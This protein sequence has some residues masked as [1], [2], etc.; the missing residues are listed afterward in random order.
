MGP[1]LWSW[2]SESDG[3]KIEGKDGFETLKEHH[4]AQSKSKRF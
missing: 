2:S 1:G 3:G 4:G